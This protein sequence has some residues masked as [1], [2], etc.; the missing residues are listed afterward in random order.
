MT[1]G[2]SDIG[3]G[4]KTYKYD[5]CEI[6]NTLNHISVIVLMGKTWSDNWPSY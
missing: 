2:E 5:S 4:T 1:V 3:N 6:E